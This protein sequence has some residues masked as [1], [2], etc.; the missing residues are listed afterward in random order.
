MRQPTANNPTPD[1]T[2]PT[3]LGGGPGPLDWLQAELGAA[4]DSGRKA[5][6]LT[7]IADAEA[8]AGNPPAALA[9]YLAARGADPHLQE[10]LEAISSLIQHGPPFEGAEAIFD[11][12]VD[13]STSADER[14]RALLTRGL[15]HSERSADLGAALAS[16]REAAAVEG[17]SAAERAAACLLLEVVAGRA[18]D[19]GTRELALAERELSGADP[20][21]RALLL[22]DQARMVAANGD[23]DAALSLLG[24][25]KAQNSRATWAALVLEEEV[26]RN[27]PG[28]DGSAQAVARAAARAQT[29]D[30]AATLVRTANADALWGDA[31]GVPRWVREPGR[32][33]D[34]WLT[35]S[36]VQRDLGNLDAAATALGS[37]EAVMATMADSERSVAATVLTHARLRLADVAG[38]RALAADLAARALTSETDGPTAAAL[39]LRIAEQAAAKGDHV[40][41]MSWLDEALRRDPTSLPARAL[42]LDALANGDDMASFAAQLEA[43]AEQLETDDARIRAF[44]VAAYAWSALANDTSSAKAA[45]SQ[46]SMLG[47]SAQVTGYLARTL[48]SLQGDSAWYEDATRRLFAALG[49]DPNSMWLGLELVALRDS[50]GDAEGASKAL[51][52]LR[53]LPGGGWPARV[54]QAFSPPSS[55]TDSTGNATTVGRVALEELAASESDLPWA[56]AIGLAAAMRA[57]AAGDLVGARRRLRQITQRAPEDLLVAS[58]LGHLD[59]QAGDHDAAAKTASNTAAALEDPE[60]AAAL[61]IAAGLEQ[62]RNGDRLAGVTSFATA[63]QSA[64]V[65]GGLALSWA[66]WGANPDDM[67]AR[68]RAIDGA[69]AYQQGDRTLSLERF[70][71]SVVGGDADAAGR[72]LDE[73][74]A[75]AD[76]TLSL[77]AALGRIAWSKAATD[78]VALRLSVDRLAERGSSAALIAAGERVRIA[79]ESQNMEQVARAAGAWFEAGGG[80][81]AALEWIAASVVLGDPREEMR[82]RLAAASC[83]SGDARAALLARAALVHSRV[84]FDTHAPL[85]PG[86]SPVVKLANLDLSPPGGDPRRR[87]AILQELGAVLGEDARIDACGLSGWSLLVAGDVAGAQRAFEGVVSARPDDLAAWEGLRTCAERTRHPAGRA[88]ACAELGRLCADPKRAA[89]FWEQ[90]ATSWFEVGDEANAERAL[91]ASFSLDASRA[92]AF[93]TLFRRLRDRK[94]HAKVLAIVARRLAVTD[95]VQEIQKL[96]WEQARALRESGDPD[97]ALRSLEQVTMLNPN[98]VGALALLGEINIRRSRFEEAATALARLALLDEAPARSRVTA[99]VAAVDLYENKLGRFD[100]SLEVLLSIHHAGVSTLPVRERLARAAARAGAWS[101]ATA[102]L[103]ELMHERPDGTQRA[104]AARLAMAIRRDRLG[105]LEGAGPA[106]VK[107]LEEAPSDPEGLDMLRRTS[108]PSDVRLRLLASART[109]LVAHLQNRPT[110]GEA[111]RQLA[112]IGRDSGD[113]AL[114]RTALAAMACLG[115][116]DSEGAETLAQLTAGVQHTAQVAISASLMQRILAPG[117]EGP[118]ADLFVLL[119][120]TLAEALG[121]N[122]QSCG[123]GRRDKI[124]PRSGLSLRNE[125]ASWA[126]AFGLREIDLYVGGND[127]L[128]IQGVAGEPPALVVGPSIKGPLSAL[129]RA[130]VARELLALLRGTTVLRWRDEVSVAAIVVAACRLAEVPI[131]HPAYAVLAEIEK[132]IG[133]ALTRRTRKSLIDVCR[134]W[135]SSKTDARTWSRR[136]LASQDRMAVI[137]GGD[138]VAVLSDVTG[139]PVD[140]LSTAI[141]SD[142]R[143]EDLLRY[144]LSADYLA[145]RA[146]LGL[147]NAP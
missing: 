14:V 86:D 37:A 20:T 43:V 70:A 104:E 44:L 5:R 102:I 7:D 93:D 145:A 139:S 112:L 110:D 8:L 3:P 33:V 36:A 59:R 124:D 120:P 141:A 26:L 51:L 54:L 117:D 77:A 142:A 113:V 55:A 41:G 96:C 78:P 105:S 109:A 74:D 28:L 39:A 121:P 63:E 94:D 24:H 123:V 127:P 135:V 42:Q 76:D 65:A 144:V 98:H 25:A 67:L 45:L 50:R 131:D 134:A 9:A 147:E 119:G 108:H 6:L 58:Y 4:Q 125:I 22:I 57:Q 23:V 11:S 1:S 71:V 88:R 34:L 82:A 73:V 114:E 75:G 126:G 97:G 101:D 52:D 122:L 68:S 53:E 48:A 31:F 80:L 95:D 128:G 87:A 60:L 56:T 66:R 2:A 116:L 100:K 140:R 29:L 132:L 19:V 61:H 35:C 69:A 115:I 81:P 136:A 64:A 32:A 47:A 146:A 18:G 91:D 15:Y 30:A 40:A 130:R 38:H 46:A 49:S 12:L 137:A 107:L 84:D 133:K 17:A 13:V 99:G 62:W 118:I 10:P 27:H 79:R 129:G 111:Q 90:A 16:L 138:P 85:V 143:A 103:E 83:L 106:I 72:A 92:G 21:W 89:A